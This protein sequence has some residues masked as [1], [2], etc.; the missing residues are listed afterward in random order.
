[1]ESNFKY[2]QQDAEVFTSKPKHI[3][4]CEV[5]PKNLSISN[6]LDMISKKTARDSKLLSACCENHAHI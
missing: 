1:M 4:I 6:I 5:A 2:K 3:N